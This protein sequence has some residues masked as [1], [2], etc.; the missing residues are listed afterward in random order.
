MKLKGRFKKGFTMVEL[1]VVMSIIGIL[2]SITIVGIQAAREKSKVSKAKTDVGRIGLAVQMFYSDTRKHPV[3][4][5]GVSTWYASVDVAGKPFIKGDECYLNDVTCTGLINQGTYG[6]S[7]KG[8]YYTGSVNDPW[9][10]PYVIDYDYYGPTHTVLATDVVR[11]VVASYGKDWNGN[12]DP[13]SANSG[14]YSC[15]DVYFEFNSIPIA[16]ISKSARP[17][18]DDNYDSVAAF[19]NSYASRCIG[20]GFKGKVN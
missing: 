11:Q 7:W 10:R 17:L 9:G 13:A 20:T 1:L 19:Y 5:N 6:A 16:S 4:S 15:D 8:P 14:M 12:R 2:A 3:G 18:G